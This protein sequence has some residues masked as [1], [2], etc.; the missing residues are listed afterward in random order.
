[1]E[2]NPRNTTAATKHQNPNHSACRCGPVAAVERE[3][4]ATTAT[5]TKPMDEMA[6]ITFTTG[7]ASGWRCHKNSPCQN[8]ANRVDKKVHK[9][10]GV[11]IGCCHHSPSDL[12]VQLRN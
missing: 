6:Y 1:M 7:E 4:R 11:K 8:V 2:R 10:C 3:S 9:P 5:P 12:C